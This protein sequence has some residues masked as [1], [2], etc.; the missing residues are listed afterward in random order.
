MQPDC[1][2]ARSGNLVV[3]QIQELVGWHVVGHD[4]L[5][6]GFHHHREDDAV[7]H[8][9]V[10]A[11]EVYQTGVLVLPPLFP[12]APFLWLAVA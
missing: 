1:P 12:L 7:E 2:V 4:V 8:D 3:L 9:V 10:L 6:V 11:D 5:A